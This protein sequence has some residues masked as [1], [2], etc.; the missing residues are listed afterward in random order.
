MFRRL[1]V[2][3]GGLLLLGIAFVPRSQADEWN[4]KT[5]FTFSEPVE[6]PGMVLPAG[7]YVFQLMDS[8]SD[9]DIVQIFN[10][11]QTKLLAAILAI[12]DYRMNPTSSPVV[13]FNERPASSPEAIDAWFYPGLNYGME[14]V[15]PRERATILAKANNRPVLA[16]EASAQAKPNELKTTAVKAVNPAGQEV[17][18]AKVITPPKPATTVAATP[19]PKMPHTASDLP[20]LAII[21]FLLLGSGFVLPRIS[22]IARVRDRSVDREAER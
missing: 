8:P 12:P 6:V 5:V 17:E 14:F 20:L 22:Q 18:M 13:K 11:D 4:E 1:M 3:L 15:Y 21:G 7:T 16:H 9:R 2:V 10:K 19:A